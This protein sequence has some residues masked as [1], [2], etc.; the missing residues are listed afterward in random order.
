MA[1]ST[2]FWSIANYFSLN[3]KPENDLFWIRLVLFFAAPHAVL[4][5]LFVFNFPKKEIKFNKKILFFVLIILFLVMIATV[6]P[7]VF[8]KIEI[9]NNQAIPIAG[10]LMPFFAV[11]V[12]G[13][14]TAGL[15]TVFKKYIRA[16]AEEKIQWRFMLIGVSLSYFLLILTNFLFVILFQKTIFVAYGPIFMLPAIFGM[17]YAILRHHLL[18]IKIIATEILTFSILS[19]A[20]ID[21]LTSRSILNFIFR[22]SAFILYLFFSIFLIRS[23]V[24]EVQQR[25][26]LEEL[27]KELAQKNEELKK[28]DEAKSQFVSITSHQLRTPLSAIKGYISMMLEELFGPVNK[29]NRSILEKIYAS[30]ERL[31]TL[32][33][34]LLNV[35][36]IESGRIRYIKTNIDLVDLLKSV[37]DDVHSELEKS[38]L[39]L[40]IN[41]KKMPKIFGDPSYLRQVFLNLIDNAIKYTPKGKITVDFDIINEDRAEEMILVSV[42]DTGLGMSQEELNSI[43]KKFSRGVSIEKYYTEGLG[44]GLFVAKEIVRDHG[45]KIWADS[46]GKGKGSVFYVALPLMKEKNIKQKV[47][48]KNYAI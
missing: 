19:V 6:S 36:R 40:K 3:V 22:F 31:I 9:K 27:T 25:E 42:Q 1:L 5:F 20:L 35:S 26:K 28:L 23:V 48:E 18:N 13:S 2:V 12:F 46:E 15:I 21:V 16:E 24:R 47:E 14:L 32:V 7:F 39:S 44:L 45:G 17:S 29:K 34:N 30:N 10:S 33:R 41:A 37:G 8:S 11:T 43:F 38:G 4:F